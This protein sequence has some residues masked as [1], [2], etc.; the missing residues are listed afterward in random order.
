MDMSNPSDF[1]AIRDMTKGVDY[2]ID[3]GE[4]AAFTGTAYRKKL[5]KA[6]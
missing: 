1:A 2:L 6:I 3:V 4:T 5:I